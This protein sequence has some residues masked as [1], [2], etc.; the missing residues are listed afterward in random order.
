MPLLAKLHR[1]GCQIRLFGGRAQE[2]YSANRVGIC[3][4][5]MKQPGA[6]RVIFP[7]LPSMQKVQASAKVCLQN[8][9]LRLTGPSGRQTAA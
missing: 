9:P 3:R 6:L 8:A 4:Y 1:Q 7:S 2:C 5:K